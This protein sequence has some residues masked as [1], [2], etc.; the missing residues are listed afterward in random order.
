MSYT[1]KHMNYRKKYLGVPLA[2]ALFCSGLQG[3]SL[4]GQPTAQDF[5]QKATANAMR[6]E[7]AKAIGDWDLGVLAD[8]ENPIWYWKRANACK[9]V[10][11]REQQA[12]DDARRA[13][14]LSSKR[15][16]FK[17]K[18]M[19]FKYTEADALQVK[20]ELIPSI[21]VL[22]PQI[23]ELGNEPYAAPFYLLRANAYFKLGRNQEALPDV[24]KAIELIPT[25]SR[26]Y[27]LRA[28]I[29]QALGDTEKAQKDRDVCLF[30][31]YDKKVDL[32]EPYPYQRLT[33]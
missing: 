20:G 2:V 29:Y 7:F 30:N 32:Y 23:Q 13:I 4:F 31:D 9:H 27:D 14:E 17:S 5:D 8:P 11:G 26:A 28:E 1:N 33:F 6:E 21:T 16:E 22:D 12:V 25:W 24:N 3:C 10:A 18:L 15:P 19:Y